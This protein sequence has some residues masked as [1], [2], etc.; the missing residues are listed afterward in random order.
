MKLFFWKIIALFSV[1]LGSLGPQVAAGSSAPTTFSEPTVV[2]IETIPVVTASLDT[3]V[4]VSQ[5]PGLSCA[6]TSF[7]LGRFDLILWHACDL[8]LQ[9]G[10]VYTAPVAVTNNQQNWPKLSVASAPVNSISS[11]FS[12][13]SAPE[14]SA[15]GFVTQVNSGSPERSTQS[16]IRQSQSVVMSQVDSEV[17]S[18]NSQ[19]T[20][21]MR[22]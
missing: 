5:G 15:A 2:Q 3:T 11:G 20:I 4:V 6:E 19:L 12:P 13:W 8:N 21:V 18:D 14:A 1:L 10:Q 7:Q 17:N 22:C 16:I 9:L